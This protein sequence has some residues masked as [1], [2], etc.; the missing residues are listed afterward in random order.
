MKLGMRACLCMSHSA[1]IPAMK[2]GLDTEK[3]DS[4]VESL[5][6]CI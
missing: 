1:S 2:S 4:P 6:S 3:R 5:M